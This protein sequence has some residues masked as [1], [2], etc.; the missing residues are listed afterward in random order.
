M[1]LPKIFPITTSD[2]CLILAIILTTTSGN[3]VP[4]ETSVNP[5]MSSETENR[6]AILVAPETIKSPPCHNKLQPSI[7]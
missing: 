4:I 7:K 6:L 2:S 1:L 5:M 3:D